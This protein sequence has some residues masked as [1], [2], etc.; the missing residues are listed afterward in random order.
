[1]NII[2]K[3]TAGCILHF[4]RFHPGLYEFENLNGI[5]S[6]PPRMASLV[7][8]IPTNKEVMIS[9]PSIP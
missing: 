4:A 2:V 6:M 3:T 5:L 7:S 9:C 1:M 8:E